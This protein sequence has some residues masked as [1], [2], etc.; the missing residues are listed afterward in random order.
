MCSF[1]SVVDDL[2]EFEDTLLD[3][4]AN[5]GLLTMLI[6]WGVAMQVD[7][8]QGH[9]RSN[10]YWRH[11]DFVATA[12]EQMREY[13][14]HPIW[15]AKMLVADPAITIMEGQRERILKICASSI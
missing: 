10:Y 3:Y 13:L 5:D 1:A 8:S 6:L 11:N 9:I 4:C 2:Q 12:L 14:Q 7:D 15:S